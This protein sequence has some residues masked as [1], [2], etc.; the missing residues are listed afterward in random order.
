MTCSNMVE[1]SQASEALK[2]WFKSQNIPPP[3]AMMVMEWFMASMILANEKGPLDIEEK[4]SIIGDTIR[5]FVEF[6]Q[7]EKLL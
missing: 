1:V 6:I 4:Y 2:A 3:D 5:S 7:K